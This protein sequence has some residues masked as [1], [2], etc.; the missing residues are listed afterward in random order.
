MLIPAERVDEE[1]EILSASGAASGSSTTRPSGGARTARC[2]DI[3][4]TVSPVSS[5]EGKSR[6][7]LE[8]R[9]RHHGP[10]ARRRSALRDAD[11][12][13]D[14]FLA[15]LA[16][17][18]RNPLAP[19]RNALPDPAA[20]PARD[21]TDRAIRRREMMERQVRPTWCGWSTICSTSAASRRGKIE[22]EQGADRSRRRSCST[23]SRRV[24][25]HCERGAT[26]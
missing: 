7:R 18:L 20:S 12:R 4:L 5:R 6:R 22:L 1:A 23:P 15:M 14:E 9:A 11:R 19:I 3:S 24:G 26:S 21:A 13:K 10:Q 8:D 16:H 17:E 2:I 25:P